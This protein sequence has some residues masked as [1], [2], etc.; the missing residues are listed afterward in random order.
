LQWHAAPTRKGQAAPLTTR[1]VGL[2]LIE[3]DENQPFLTACLPWDTKFISGIAGA[4]G[5]DLGHD[6]IGND[7][8]CDGEWEGFKPW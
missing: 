1:H 5:A 7:I 2:S 6:Q 8:A 3:I 4:P